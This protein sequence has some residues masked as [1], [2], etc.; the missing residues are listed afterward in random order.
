MFKALF[1]FL[2]IAMVLTVLVACQDE[3]KTPSIVS[4]GVNEYGEWVATFDDDSEQIITHD[5]E[6]I[7]RI[8]TD[9]QDRLVLHFES[10]GYQIYDATLK[11]DYHHVNFFVDDQLHYFQVV[12]DGEDAYEPPT[13]SIEGR[14]FARWT[15]S[16]NQITSDKNIHAEF[17]Y[18]EYEVTVTIED[19]TYDTI[20]KSVFHGGTLDLPDVEKTDY[21]FA[22]YY[23]EDTYDTLFDPSQ[24]ITEDMS[25]YAKWVH[26]NAY[27]PEL[28]DE[29]LNLLKQTHYKYVDDETFY[30]YAI[31]GLI[32]AL[33]DPY[34]NYMTPEEA[35]RWAQ[36][37]GES[38]V[39]VGITIENINDNVV[40]RKV[41]T[42]SPAERAGLSPG[43]VITHIDG[44]DYRNK[45]YTD[46]VF[47]LLGE[48]DTTVEI[49]V[50][51]RGFSDILYFEMT[52]EQIPNPTVEHDIIEKDGEILGY[53]KINS[54]GSETA[55]N[56]KAALDDL[57]AQDIDGLIIDLRNN[58][59]GYLGA[60][61]EMMDVF[62]PAGDLPLMHISQMYGNR[63]VFEQSYPASGTEEKPYDIVVL[64]NHF[65]A[66]ASEV[67]S[68]AMKEKGGYDL[69]GTHTFGKGT[70]QI[71]ETLMN[72]SE[73]SFSVG[74]WYTPEGRWIH[75]NEGDAD[76]IYPTIEVKQNPYFNAFRILISDEEALVYDQVSSQ[77]A[78]AQ[79]ILN[80]M[81]YDLRDDGYF[82]QET[83]TAVLDI[84]AENN[85]E[86][87]GKIDAQ[88]ADVISQ[89]LLDYIQDQA[90]DTQLQT[91]IQYFI[92]D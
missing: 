25:L 74:K 7:E 1:K 29:V 10:G 73:L 50:S 89:W 32:K 26:Q 39:G 76:Y 16:L 27:G 18:H 24:P 88:T 6:I 31:E 33:D 38:F 65:S 70:M 15:E 82:D 53:L 63:F 78:N 61:I 36:S 66:S 2:A 42:D 20:T 45:S 81:G 28:F 9:N 49:G 5:K 54:F 72:E 64:I 75:E 22:G 59:G 91:A 67:F 21:L 34:T 86:E 57:E 8:S 44:V 68:A 60:V 69:I 17:E 12:L 14:T 79:I 51:R 46:T 47:D 56:M 30:Q 87:T 13:P 48:E 4:L 71:R 11:L 35:E 55:S 41:W 52:R 62:L 3:A 90:N 43:D 40:I 80:A 19:D 85:L 92:E 77:I 84:Q 23:L 37:L 58:G 83:K